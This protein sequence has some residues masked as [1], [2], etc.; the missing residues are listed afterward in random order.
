M[1]NHFKSPWHY[2]SKHTTA[3]RTWRNDLGQIADLGELRH[4]SDRRVHR[5]LLP[6]N[7]CRMKTCLPLP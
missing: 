4:V 7:F 2:D 6:K 5:P 3:V 1:C